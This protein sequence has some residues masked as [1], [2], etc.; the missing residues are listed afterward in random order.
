MFFHVYTI[1][2]WRIPILPSEESHCFRLNQMISGV[3]RKEAVEG[4]YFSTTL[5]TLTRTLSYVLNYWLPTPRE[6]RNEMFLA[7]AG[8]SCSCDKGNLA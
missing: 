4:I 8:L 1:G 2:E 5:K 6:V 3:S 7:G